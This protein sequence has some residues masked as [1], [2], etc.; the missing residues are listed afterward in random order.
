MA[1]QNSKLQ[2]RKFTVWVAWLVITGL[3]VAFAP[4]IT[5]ITK[6]KY[7]DIISL[8]KENL[9]NMFYISMMYLGMNV[10]QKG[11]F[12][13]AD[14]IAAKKEAEEDANNGGEKNDK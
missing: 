1:N 3:I 13:I 6:T 11:A 8:V 7:D 4:T 2:S 10:A 14:V 5:I 12:A 9:N